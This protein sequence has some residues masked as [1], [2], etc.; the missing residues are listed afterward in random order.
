MKITDSVIIDRPIDEVFA[1]AGDPTKDAD[2]STAFVEARMTSD[3]PVGKG[4]TFV[5]QLRFLGKRID[6]DCELTEYEPEQRVAYA[7]TAGSNT[8]T[9]V[10]TFQSVDGGTQVTFLTE[11]DSTGLFKIADPM[12]NKVGTRQLTADLLALKAMIEAS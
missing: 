3:G 7:L 5:E 2:W 1:Y 6:I 10:R 4:S 12:L 8:G 11:G 9:H